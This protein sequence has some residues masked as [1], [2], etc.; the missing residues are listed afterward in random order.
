MRGSPGGVVSIGSIPHWSLS[1]A[2][3]EYRGIKELS[4]DLGESSGF[5]DLGTS[6]ASP[7]SGVTS[8]LGQLDAYYGAQ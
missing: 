3:D 6:Q 5:T 2:L 1:D 8:I 4:R 7:L